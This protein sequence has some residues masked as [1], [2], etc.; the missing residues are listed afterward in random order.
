[1]AIFMC[2]FCAKHRKQKNRTQ[3]RIYAKWS[4]YCVMAFIWASSM[5]L[6]T[7]KHWFNRINKLQHCKLYFLSLSATHR[8][9]II[10]DGLAGWLAC[11]FSVT[12]M[13]RTTARIYVF[14]SVFCVWKFHSTGLVFVYLETFL[15]I[16]MFYECT[17]RDSTLGILILNFFYHFNFH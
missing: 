15:R 7:P 9:F 3:W 4:I 13:S 17:Q 2:F 14:H 12:D 5:C 10:F 1:M 8:L 11:F 16:L 6:H